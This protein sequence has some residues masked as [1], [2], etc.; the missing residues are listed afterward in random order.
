MENASSSSSVTTLGLQDSQMDMEVD[1]AYHSP[2]RD[3][4]DLEAVNDQQSVP[5]LQLSSQEVRDLVEGVEFSPPVLVGEGTRFSDHEVP[6]LLQGVDF[7][8]PVLEGELATSSNR[9]AMQPVPSTSRDVPQL[10]VPPPVELDSFSP[11]SPSILQPPPV[12]HLKKVM[13]NPQSLF[14]C[15]CDSAFKLINYNFKK[16]EFRSLLPEEI[17]DEM[18]KHFKEKFYLV[19]GSYYLCPQKRIHCIGCYGK[20]EHAEMYKPHWGFTTE[21]WV[22]EGRTMF[23]LEK[24]KFKDYEANGPYYKECCVCGEEIFTKSELW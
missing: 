13:L 6:E 10:V 16:D 9:V 4:A 23:A 17:A 22:R 14:K 15:A 24:N 5:G 20:V 19:W 8:V 1:D 3:V 12:V 18:I 21:G 11:L 7:S 2:P